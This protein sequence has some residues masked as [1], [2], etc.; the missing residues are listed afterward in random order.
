M[1][2]LYETSPLVSGVFPS[3]VT[4]LAFVALAVVPTVIAVDYILMHPSRLRTTSIRMAR[5]TGRRTTAKPWK[6]SVESTNCTMK[7]RNSAM[8]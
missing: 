8:R 5:K 7:F 2:V 3:V 6:I 1:L 4:W